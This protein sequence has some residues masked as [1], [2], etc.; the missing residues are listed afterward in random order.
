MPEREPFDSLSV[1]IPTYNRQEVLAKALAGYLAQSRPELIH[2]LIVVD[3]GSTD[4]TESRV[5]EF[6]QR[7]LF[8]IHYLRQPNKGPAAAQNLGI[9]QARSKL[10]LFTDSDIVPER[11]LVEQHIRWH[12]S[13]R[14]LSMAVLGYVTWPRQIR[15]T[16][17]MRWY[18][19]RQIFAFQRLQNKKEEISFHFFYTCNVSLKT[20]FLRTCGQFDEE[21]KSAA[22]E[23]IELGYRLTK[24]DLRLFYNPEAVGYHHQFFL[25]ADACRKT[26]AHGAAAQ[27]FLTKEAGQQVLKESQAVRRTF[28]Y[29]LTRRLAAAMARVLHPVRRLLDSSLPLPGIV[30]YLFF[31]DSTRQLDSRDVESGSGTEARHGTLS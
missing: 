15:P 16:P 11:D 4:E 17:F 19:E 23:D 14:A 20:E 21:F 8:T 3:D 24:C 12:Q 5:G 30:Y 13:H 18:G 28:R 6:S 2:E 27:T 26:L 1:V 31:W 10:I 29:K 22:Y 9:Q 25:F 7:S